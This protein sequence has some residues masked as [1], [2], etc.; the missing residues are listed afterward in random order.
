MS[1]S[2]QRAIIVDLLNNGDNVPANIAENT[3]YSREHV[4]RSL[5]D[6]EDKG[7][8]SNKGRGVWELTDKGQESARDAVSQ[9]FQKPE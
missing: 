9:G 1:T 3:G 2:A 5:S 6:L 8:V 7:L 4:Q